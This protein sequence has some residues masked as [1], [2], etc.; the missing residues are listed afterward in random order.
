MATIRKRCWKT[1]SGVAKSAWV[2]SYSLAGKRHIKT[3]ALKKSA[4]QWQAQT[5]TEIAHG[6]H[7]PVSTS[8]TV[9][10]AAE[11]WLEQCRTD[12]LERATQEQYEQHCRTRECGHEPPSPTDQTNPRPEMAVL[13]SLR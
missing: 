8:I 2:V 13:W 4:E 1:P 9:A 11:L 6:Q 3:F 7:A 5:L 10:K 12:G